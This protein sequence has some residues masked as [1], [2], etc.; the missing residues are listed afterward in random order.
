MWKRDESVRPTDPAS[1]I[2]RPAAQEGESEMRASSTSE[3]R[4][5]GPGII[6]GSKILI[7]GELVGNEDL[8]INGKVEGKIELRHNVLTIGPDGKIWAQ[9]FAKS[10]IVLGEVI[11]NVTATEKVEI[12]DNGS[13]DGDIAAPRV[14]IAEGAHFR[15]SIDMQRAAQKKFVPA[16][17]KM[18]VEVYLPDADPRKDI[19]RI[20]RIQRA[21]GD[22]LGAVGYEPE[23]ESITVVHGSWRFKEWFRNNKPQVKREASE[24]YDGIKEAL[25]RQQIDLVGADAFQKRATAA[26]ELLKALDGFDAVVR[27]GDVVIAKAMVNG[28]P[29]AVVQTISPALARELER[30]PTLIQDPGAFFA[31]IDSGTLLPPAA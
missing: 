17:A 2:H 22:L 7:R 4:P 15:G 12:T 23:P 20:E 25:T 21:L 13:V 18:L 14:S 19:L 28:H 1:P 31:L 26:A 30:N 16:P 11:G 6:L 10:V 5:G 27:L 9:V 3:P 29:R 24:V 8:T